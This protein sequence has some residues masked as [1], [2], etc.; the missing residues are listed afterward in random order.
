MLIIFVV[1]SGIC[2]TCGTV[3]VV[4]NVEVVNAQ[5]TNQLTDDEKNTIIEKCGLN[6]KNILF[7]LK[8]EQIAKNVKSVDPMFKLHSVTAKFPNRVIL[9]VSRRVPIFYDKQNK[10][11]FDAE[12]CIVDGTGFDCVD[13]SG[14]NLELSEGLTFGDL[15]TS[16]NQRSQAKINQLKTI[17]TYFDSLD[18]FEIAYDDTA[19]MVGTEFLYL[20]LTIKTGVVFQI[21]IKPSDDFLYAL[22]FTDQ[23]YQNDAHQAT[24]VYKT[25]RDDEDTG[26]FVVEFGGREYYAEK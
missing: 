21:K 24:G 5:S 15:A 2:I 17:A 23:I 1:V 12:M 25:V 22:E 13:I 20:N 8:Q 11:W 6:G 26:K 4:R 16:S 9:V 18:G 10:K 3:F 14:A 7:N 19:A